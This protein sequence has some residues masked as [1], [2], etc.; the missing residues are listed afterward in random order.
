MPSAKPNNELPNLKTKALKSGLYAASAVS[1]IIFLI[2]AGKSDNIINTMPLDTKKLDDAK[3]NITVP[4]AE[5]VIITATHLEATSDDLYFQTYLLSLTEDEKNKIR[6]LNQMLFNLVSHPSNK[7][8]ELLLSQGYPS[9]SELNFI[10]LNRFDEVSIRLLNNKMENYPTPSDTPIN[11]NALR[12]LN[13]VNT[14]SE[15][16]KIISY[17]HVD[18]K[19]SAGE[20]PHASWTEGRHEMPSQVKEALASLVYANAALSTETGMELLAKAKFEEMMS[21]WNNEAA[22]D[23]VQLLKYLSAANKKL[24]I[25]GIDDYV[26]LKF[27]E[28]YKEYL[29]F[30]DVTH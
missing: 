10:S 29:T 18:F 6:L 14:V 13:F 23:N 9:K 7:A 24:P 15:I 5:S 20:N 2:Y 28:K 30:R 22:S 19:F 12:V 4:S 16:E 8:F 1:A 21:Y 11:E 27:P 26:K 25:L 17:Y 3:T